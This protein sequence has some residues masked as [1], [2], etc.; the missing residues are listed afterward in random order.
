MSVQNMW[1]LAFLVVIPVIILLYLLKQKVKDQPFS[2]TLLWQEIYKN[3]EANTPFE[4]LKQNI[5]MYLQIFLMLLLIFALMAPVLNKGG[6]VQENAV[7]V[8]DNSASMQY[9]YEDSDSRLDYSIKQAEREID[10]LS[11]NSTITLIACNSEASVVYQG[12]D[13]TTIK[14]RLREIQPTLEVGNLDLATNLVNSLVTDLPNVQII[15][16][17]DTDFGSSQWT[18][19]NEK[20]A[21]V[22]ENVYSKG[23]N[24]SLDYVSYSVDEVTTNGASVNG[25][26]EEQ[27]E[28]NKSVA[29][30]EALAKVTNY[31]EE[32]VTQD[33]SLYVNAD[34]V[35]VQEVTV[36]A[37]DSE[38][39]Y[40]NSQTIPVD[41]S[42]ILRAELS[43]KDALVA[44]N[45]QAAVVTGKTEKNILLLSEG[46]VFLEKALSLEENVTVYKSDDVSVL[47][48]TVGDN[49]EPFDM[50]VFDG[51]TL[52]EEF[53]VSTFPEDAA[54]FFVNQD[55]D[56]YE[57]GYIEKENEVTNQVLSFT[58]SDVT[59][60]AEN[61]AFGITKAH[62]YALPE[63]GLPFVKTDTGNVVGYYGNAEGHN[64]AVMGFDI[65]NTDLALQTEFPIVMSQLSDWLLGGT[66]SV[67]EIVN[68]PVA[69]ESNVIPVDAVVLEGNKENRKT[70]GR[71]I[72]NLL[73]IFA[74][75][76][77]IVEWIIY[78]Y[79]VNSNKK[80]Q[81]LV[82]RT[83]VLLL[84]ILAIAGVSVSKKQKKAETIFLVD[85]SDSMSGNIEEMEDYLTETIATMPDKNLA[86]VVA[87]GKDTAVDQ[88]L[89]DKKIFAEFT[90]EPVTIA[91]N[92]E[93]AITTACGMFDEGVT[94]RLVLITDG[95]ENEGN[96]NLAATTLKGRGVELYAIAM[97]DSVSGNREVYI[98]GL[99][100]PSVIHV[101]DHYN[102]IV[103]VTSNVETDALLSLYSGRIAK[104]QQQIRLNKGKNQFVFEDVGEEGTIA[105]YKAV[106]EPVEDTISVN[107]TYVNFAEIQASPKVLLVEGPAGEAEEFQ[108]VLDAAN[109]GYDT[110]T[111]TAVPVTL[112]ELNRYKAVITLNAHYDDMRDGFA[113]VLDSYV[114]DYAGG[115]ICIGGDNSF[116]LGNYRGTKLE[117]MLPVNMDLQGEKEV[118]KMAMTFVIDQSGSMTT[119]SE[120]SSTV[121][122]L[123][124]AKQA[125]LSGVD[126]LR[127]SDEA[128][129]LAFDD[130]FN[131]VVALQQASDPESL[132]DKIRT[133]GYG[134]GTSIYPALQEAYLKMLKSDAKLKHIIL[135]TDG[136]DGH[137]QYSELLEMINAA[138][139]TVSTVAVGV[140]SDQSTLSKIAEE[141]GGR[142][143]YTDV[144][145]SIPRIFAQ[146]VYLSTNTYLINE[147]F[148]PVITSNNAILN[149]VMDEG[150]PALMGYIAATPKQT[151]DV[152]LQSDRE[153][154]ILSTWQYGLGRTVAWNSDGNNEWTAQYAT[155]ENYPMLWSNIIH[156]V[157]SDT[158]LGD[159]TLEVTKEGNTAVIAYETKEYDKDTKV[160][161]VVSDENGTP[162]E[163]TLDAVK[164]GSFEATVDM[165]EIGVYSVSLRRMKGDKVEKNYNTAYAN[166]YSAEYQFTNS[167]TNLETL[168]K[169]ADG[170]SFTMEENVWDLE[171]QMVKAKIS[172]TVPLLILAILLFLFDII[173]RRFSFDVVYY[174]KI[175][176]GKMFAKVKF[177]R[178]RAK[179]NK[180]TS[181]IRDEKMRAH[182]TEDAVTKSEQT[183]VQIRDLQQNIENQSENASAQRHEAMSVQT[184]VKT[185]SKKEKKSV[186][187]K[188]DA[189]NKNK[190]NRNVAGQNEKLDMNALLKKK[191]DR[192]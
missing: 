95:S 5:L 130:S 184:A 51:V 120:E 36:A 177:A 156:Y 8:V 10:G 63:W 38:T 100:V 11:E 32:T 77:L 187:A 153:D 85:V 35:D 47:Y 107:N 98:D 160:V 9:L 4:K 125:A 81:F 34:I 175:F 140:G 87:F 147:E 43:A 70:G 58:E 171:Q 157:I 150:C 73:L 161:A 2:S 158:E 45:S 30:V 21:L 103:S 136:Q 19:G 132:K 79:Q 188:K 97:E 40:F 86:G 90:T 139:I 154:P 89:S 179:H 102:V 91:T 159:D 178:G 149:G 101:G 164:P 109:I 66:I 65:H 152:I 134:G 6:A 110:V 75:L 148:H 80:K 117:E 182:L 44:D 108:K 1:P 7:I 28:S 185:S 42:T 165:E 131:W 114:K 55:K 50:Y 173:I 60:Y 17:T 94:K 163:I 167:E 181:V 113:D 170:Q 56:F 92:I 146:E 176:C 29:P 128:G 115:Y 68:F 119:P 142:F 168:V 84:V 48:Q 72:R 122:G 24:C 46:N 39:I 127:E 135:L 123:D 190:D 71:A 12:T 57:N 74:I 99:E 174:F 16:Y 169:Q 183:V 83:M 76:F 155:W 27:D 192:S 13:K 121:T 69:E 15:C 191:Q 64:V 166:Q 172:L 133:I 180:K 129:V 124:L 118:P 14:H 111:P 22:V 61:Y 20:A 18:K 78:V 26:T 3:L 93:K 62:T 41:G 138:G 106:I 53:D 144:N 126:T 59:V 137:N 105:E 96:M 33:V 67:Q 25:I 104:G 54:F 52:P 23:E 116:A 31:G 151:A 186:S 88:F 145:N 141:C 143:Y 189:N 49:G 82:V 162:R 37:G 112:S